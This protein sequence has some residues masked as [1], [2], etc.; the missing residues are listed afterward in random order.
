MNK[1]E[2]VAEVSSFLADVIQ[3]LLDKLPDDPMDAETILGGITSPALL[4]V[5]RIFKGGVSKGT[6]I[7]ELQNEIEVHQTITDVLTGMLKE[8]V[9][10]LEDDENYY[11]KETKNVGTD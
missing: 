8:T 5:Y 3:A 10:L 1:D 11:T 2:Q 7:E 6:I 9:I 4:D